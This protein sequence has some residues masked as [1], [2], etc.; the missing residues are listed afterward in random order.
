MLN[1][2]AEP[3]KTNSLAKFIHHQ[4]FTRENVNTFQQTE[5]NIQETI[6]K[7]LLRV[8]V[9]AR[10]GVEALPVQSTPNVS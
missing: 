6:N 1:F 5:Q 7:V 8:A 10:V 2:Q 9:I 4:H 3:W